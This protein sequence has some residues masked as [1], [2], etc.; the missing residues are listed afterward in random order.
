[1]SLLRETFRGLKASLSGG[2]YDQLQFLF[3]DLPDDAKTLDLTFCIHHAR[4]AEFIFKP[5]AAESK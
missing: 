5:P 3:F 1:M 4:T 2:S